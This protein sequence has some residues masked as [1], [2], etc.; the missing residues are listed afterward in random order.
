MQ[1]N[2]AI[3]TPSLLLSSS[4]PPLQVLFKP[5]GKEERVWRKREREE[6]WGENEWIIPNQG[7]GWRENDWGN[8]SSNPSSIWHAGEWEEWN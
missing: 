1:I 8:P 7:S 5:I 3:N 6:E 2:M 4:L